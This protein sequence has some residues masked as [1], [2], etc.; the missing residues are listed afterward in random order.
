M[1]SPPEKVPVLFEQVYL[2]SAMVGMVNKEVYNATNYPLYLEY[3]TAEATFDPRG[4]LVLLNEEDKVRTGRPRSSCGVLIRCVRRC[5]Y[6]WA[7]CNE[8]EL[9]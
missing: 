6:A 1:E 3:V 7:R 5:V 8:N 2:L 4:Q 9:S